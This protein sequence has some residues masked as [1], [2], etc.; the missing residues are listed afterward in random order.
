MADSTNVWCAGATTGPGDS[1]DS[2]TG[3]IVSKNGVGGD[4]AA[5]TTVSAGMG[6]VVATTDDGDADAASI[7]VSSRAGCAE[8]SGNTL[9]IGM[10]IVAARFDACALLILAFFAPPPTS[11]TSIRTHLPP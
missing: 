3:A 10:G 11:E 5:G 9:C 4:A 7:V 1:A 8:E 6:V 2:S